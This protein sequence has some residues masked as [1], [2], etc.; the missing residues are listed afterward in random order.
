MLSFRLTRQGAREVAAAIPESGRHSWFRS[1][2][3]SQ[4]LAQSV[5][6]AVRAFDRLDLLEEV[7][8]DCGRPAFPPMPQGMRLEFEHEPGFLGEPRPTSVDIWLHGPEGRAAVECKFTERDFGVCSQTKP[9]RPPRRFCDGTYRVQQ[10]RRERCALTEIGVLYWRYLPRLFDWPAD[11]D[12]RPCPFRDV[13]QLGRNALAAAV[14]PDGALEA[15]RGHALVMYDA[16][17]PE[18]R[19]NGRAGRQWAAAT[20]AC[21]IP[22]LLRRA[23]WQR[24]LA[25]LAGAGELS[26]LI[27][28]L[29]AKYGL[30][31]R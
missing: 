4:A 28:D 26:Y 23:S 15:A 7:S 25:A 12:H 20:E 1:L 27:D 19:P 14:A 16:R 29:E 22:G 9:G 30:R 21:R 8:A 13:Y 10:G 6:G 18:F 2:K 24:L 17:N 3:S 11:R 5:F 31:P